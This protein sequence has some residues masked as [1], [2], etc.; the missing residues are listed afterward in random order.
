MFSGMYSEVNRLITR[1]KFKQEVR[2]QSNSTMLCTFTVLFIL[3]SKLGTTSLFQALGQS[4]ASDG[5]RAK[6]KKPRGTANESR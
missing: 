6:K 4:D 1:N 3:F 5:E 2:A